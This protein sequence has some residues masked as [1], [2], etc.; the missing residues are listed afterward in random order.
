MCVVYLGSEP[1]KGFQESGVG[2]GGTWG[3][4]A[5]V[6]EQVAAVGTWGPPV[7]ALGH[8]LCRAHSEL[9]HGVEG[10]CLSP[11][12]HPYQLRVDGAAAS[13]T[14]SLPCT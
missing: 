5:H 2:R 11:N 7:G 1:R 4:P 14:A 6:M 9:S 12:S 8:H 3:S 10:G 13:C